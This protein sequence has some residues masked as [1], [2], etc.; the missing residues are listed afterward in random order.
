MS[1]EAT[2]T[3][4]ILR[5]RSTSYRALG[6]APPEFAHVPMILGADGERLSKR[7][8]AVSVLQYRDEGYLP[9]AVFNYLARL[10]WSHGDEELF[11]VS[12][13]VEWFDLGHISARPLNSTRKSWRGSITST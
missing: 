13:F 10:G 12:Q 9:E 8:G 11:S 6:A 3:S 4:T 5:A 1:S 2:T 7:H